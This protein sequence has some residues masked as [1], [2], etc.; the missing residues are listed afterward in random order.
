MSELKTLETCF[1]WVCLAYWHG[2]ASTPDTFQSFHPLPCL[3]YFKQKD[4]R[5]WGGDLPIHKGA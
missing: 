2:A 1:G 3:S 4:D 5:G